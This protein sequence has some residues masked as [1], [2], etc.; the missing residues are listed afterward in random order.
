LGGRLT[1]LQKA[2]RIGKPVVLVGVDRLRNCPVESNAP[3]C[4][5]LIRS[6]FAVRHA[7]LLG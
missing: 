1:I 2:L 3:N 6:E 4:G 7:M 5:R